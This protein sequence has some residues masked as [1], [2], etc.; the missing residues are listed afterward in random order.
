[1]IVPALPASAYKSYVIAAPLATHWNAV[2][3]AQYECEHHALGWDSVID[4]RTD[5]GQEQAGYIRGKSGRRFT[6]ERQPDGLTRFSFEAGQKCFREHKAR[7]M[8]PERFLERDG[9]FRGNPTRRRR[10][11]ARPD[12]WLESFAGHQD[13]LATIAERG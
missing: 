7:N 12:D 8:R 6:E 3:C 1:V 10:E 13:R 4:E 5:L 2:T 11:F 9:D